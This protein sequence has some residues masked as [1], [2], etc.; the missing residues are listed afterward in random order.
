MAKEPVNNS[1]SKLY[2]L[3]SVLSINTLNQL[4]DDFI[5][6]SDHQGGVN[7]DAS[8]VEKVDTASVQMI[9]AFFRK[10]KQQSFSVQWLSPSE[11]LINKISLLGLSEEMNLLSGL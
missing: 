8:S 6:L 2:V 11:E 10:K 5:V 9:L 3:E 4:Y 1:D 7:I